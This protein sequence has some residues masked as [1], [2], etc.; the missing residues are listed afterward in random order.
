MPGGLHIYARISRLIS[1]G[2]ERHTRLVQWGTTWVGA[3]F[4]HTLAMVVI[5]PKPD[6]RPLQLKH[7]PSQLCSLRTCLPSPE[8]RATLIVINFHIR[9]AKEACTSHLRFWSFDLH[10]VYIPQARLLTT[11]LLDWEVRAFGLPVCAE[12]RPG[13]TRK[14]R[15]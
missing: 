15:R 2:H 4:L 5:S 13:R 11:L 10:P 14:L 3:N 9:K 8:E 12:T 6:D 7:F 1:E